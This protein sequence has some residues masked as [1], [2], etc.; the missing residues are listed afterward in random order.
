MEVPGKTP[1]GTQGLGLLRL[2]GFQLPI[3]LL[4]GPSGAQHEHSTG[5]PPYLQAIFDPFP[6]QARLSGHSSAPSFRPESLGDFPL[7]LLGIS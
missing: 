6:S 2:L 7:P 5:G 3:P 4:P 1:Q